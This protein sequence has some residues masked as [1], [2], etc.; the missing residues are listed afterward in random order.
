MT[1]RIRI[2][3]YL[4]LCGLGSRRGVENLIVKGRISVNGEKISDLSLTIDPDS[5]IIKY[6]NRRL[7]PITRK[8]YLILNKPKGY[9]TS[10]RDERGRPIVMDLIPEKYKRAGVFPVGRLDKDTEGLLLFTNDGETSYKLAHPKYGIQKEYLVELNLPLDDKTKSR[11]ENG[12]FL[13][14]KKTKPATVEFVGGN[15]KRIKMIIYEGMKRQ[16]KM[17][18]INFGYRVKGLRRYSFGPLNLSGIDTGSFRL[19]KA[20][21]IKLIKKI[22]GTNNYHP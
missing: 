12:I 1:K 3:K 13:Y 8:Y 6:D 18:F 9:I 19:L 22:T 5:D 10:T 17:T 11:I 14:G 15:R 16:V 20:R 7:N 21:E 2:N 4:A